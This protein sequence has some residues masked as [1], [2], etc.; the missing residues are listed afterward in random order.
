MDKY[1]YGCRPSPFDIRDHRVRAVCTQAL[2]E[3]FQLDFS[4]IAIKNQKSVSSCVA[5]AMSTILEYHAKG[6]YTLSTN[7]IYGIRKRLF[8]QEGKGMY[9]RDACKIVTTYGDPVE[10]D[11]PGNTEIPNVYDIASRALDNEE[12]MRSAADF[13]TKSY[14]KCDTIEDVKAA[15]CNYGP[16]LASVKWYDDFK[17]SKGV[18]TGGKSKGYGYHAIVI[19]GYNSQGFLC[20]NSW[21]KYWGDK[22][23]FILPYEIE[24]RE[25]RGLVDMDNDN[26]VTPPKIKGFWNTLYKILNMIVNLFRRD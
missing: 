6:K 25:A 3:E 19:Y 26:Y 9:L 20:Q 11:C 13:R 8:A 17:V 5:H 7:F 21:G 24:L 18:L 22:G 2:P 10:E 14:Y 4:D 16:I 12:I 15:L 1:I 23:R